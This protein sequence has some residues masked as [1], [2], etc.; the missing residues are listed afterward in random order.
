MP[1]KKIFI[2]ILSFNIYEKGAMHS[3]DVVP[4]LKEIAA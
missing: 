4:A 1:S 3:L 2:F